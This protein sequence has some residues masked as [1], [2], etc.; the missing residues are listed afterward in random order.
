[1]N[2]KILWG[3]NIE[4]EKACHIKHIIRGGKHGKSSILEQILLLWHKIRCLAKDMKRFDEI[5][6]SYLTFEILK[7]PIIGSKFKVVA[8]LSSDLSKQARER[9]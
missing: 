9:H 3:E 2:S 6:P 5:W 1:M 7:I 4:S 8:D